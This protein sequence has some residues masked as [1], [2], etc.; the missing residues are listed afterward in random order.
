LDYCKYQHRASVFCFAYTSQT[1]Y[2]RSVLVIFRNDDEIPIMLE[3]KGGAWA[4]QELHLSS[5]TPTEHVKAVA[6]AALAVL[7]S[8]GNQAPGQTAL[9]LM[10]CA[11]SWADVQL[12]NNALPF[13][14]LSPP[15]V[16]EAVGKALDAFGLG[17]IQTG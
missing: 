17:S 15:A 6:S 10:N 14:P 5:N 13:C 4:I 11:I 9:P 3:V 2:D 12:W 7:K 1:G 16:G 8:G